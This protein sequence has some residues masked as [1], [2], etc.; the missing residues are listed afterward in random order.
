MPKIENGNALS[1]TSATETGENVKGKF[2]L[3]GQG[4]NDAL[5]EKLT[6][7]V[8]DGK[9]TMDQA[10]E[11]VR[12]DAEDRATAAEL[13]SR[14]QLEQENDRLRKRVN[15]LKAQMKVSEQKTVRKADTDRMSREILK[16]YDSKADRESVRAQVKAL[17]D[18][19]V[20][21]GGGDEGMSWNCYKWKR[22]TAGAIAPAVSLVAPP[23]GLE[24]TTP[25]LTAACSTD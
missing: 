5:V 24:P 25:R 14:K 19:L 8:R 3:K 10:L 22:E 13:N 4:A 1:G 2:S 12:Q 23:V 7:Q 15:A 6:Q 16:A 20:E 18:Y 11:Q 9:I 17:G 21:S